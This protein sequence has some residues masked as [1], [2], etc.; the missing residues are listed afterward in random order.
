M[1]YNKVL[2]TIL[3]AILA[4]SSFNVSATSTV[5]SPISNIKTDSV[6]T[7]SNSISPMSYNS[8]FTLDFSQASVW[9]LNF[10][11]NSTLMFNHKKVTVKYLTSN[12]SNINASVIIELYIDEDKDGTYVKYDP[13]GGYRYTIKNGEALE[14]TL[15]YGN[16]VKNYRFVFENRTSSVTSGTFSVK[17]S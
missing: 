3:V 13:T 12:P 14:I 10:N 4:F 5:D 16:T 9:T 1:K 7:I 2:A 15:P 6:S 11:N 17:T 8:S